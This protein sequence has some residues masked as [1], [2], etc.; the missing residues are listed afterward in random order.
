MTPKRKPPF[1]R[2]PDVDNAFFRMWER[3]PEDNEPQGT[4]LITIKGHEGEGVYETRQYDSTLIPGYILFFISKKKGDLY[5][6]AGRANR[7]DGAVFM[8]FQGDD[9]LTLGD[10]EAMITKITTNFRGLFDVENPHIVDGRHY[11][12]YMEA[13]KQ[14][15]QKP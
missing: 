10:Y 9:W 3:K 8:K 2:E 1:D 5:W 12:L 7:P 13:A 4:P 6:I 11:Q 14:R 15:R